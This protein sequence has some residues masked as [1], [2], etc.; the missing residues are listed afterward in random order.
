MAKQ[1]S[2]DRRILNISVGLLIIILLSVIGF[3]F[4]AGQEFQRMQQE[5]ASLRTGQTHLEREIV[6]NEGRIISL[7]GADGQFNVELAKIQTKLN[8][9]EALLIELKADLKTR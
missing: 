5:I 1:V 6:N 9:I 3:A 7:E 8:S 2:I 4:N